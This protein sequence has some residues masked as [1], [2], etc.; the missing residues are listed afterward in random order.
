MPHVPGAPNV[1]GAPIYVMLQFNLLGL[2]PTQLTIL[3]S[4]FVQFFFFFTILTTS[5]IGSLTLIIGCSEG[6]KQ[7]NLLNIQ[8]T[9]SAYFVIFQYLIGSS[10]IGWL[11]I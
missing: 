6:A 2:N 7:S 1:P 4:M 8:A 10:L 5:R 3:H 11:K 9:A